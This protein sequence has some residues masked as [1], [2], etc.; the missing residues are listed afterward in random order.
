MRDYLDRSVAEMSIMGTLTYPG[1]FE[2]EFWSETKQHWRRFAARWRRKYASDRGASLFWFVEFQ[3]RGAPHF[4]FFTN[5]E[6]DKQW[7]AESWWDC[8]GR[9]SEAHLR[10]GTRIERLRCG[11]G[12]AI[13]YAAKYAAKAEQKTVPRLRGA[14][15]EIFEI[16]PG[17]WWGVIGSRDT[18]PA[19]KVS[20]QLPRQKTQKNQILTTISRKKWREFNDKLHGLV[21]KGAV[22]GRTHQFHTT[23]FPLED[24]AGCDLDALWLEV[25]GSHAPKVFHQAKPQQNKKIQR[26]GCSAGDVRGAGTGSDSIGNC[27]AVRAEMPGKGRS[28][29]N[30]GRGSGRRI[31]SAAPGG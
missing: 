27:E 24:A 12:G 4:H 23:F 5:R 29:A 15:G 8:L 10:A 20:C 28:T 3:R 1:E 18:H 31:A 14:S 22:S 2:P 6:I 11:H 25:G 16:F 19:R 26:E 17:R 30:G 7:L 21:A 9:R 13:A